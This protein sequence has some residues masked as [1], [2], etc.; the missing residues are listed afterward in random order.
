MLTFDTCSAEE[1]FLISSS[2]GEVFGDGLWVVSSEGS[3][4]ESEEAWWSD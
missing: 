2:F 3:I 1:G 4:V